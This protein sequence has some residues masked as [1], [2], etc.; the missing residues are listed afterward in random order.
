MTSLQTTGQLLLDDAPLTCSGC[1][2]GG[3][4]DLEERGPRE[5]WPAWIS[6]RQ[7]GHGED[8]QV[9]TN[10][11][12]AAAAAA[13]TGR[14]RAEDADTFTAEWRHLTLAGECVPEFVLDDAV[15]LGQEL[16]KIG[17][18]EIKARKRKARRWF[19]HSTTNTRQR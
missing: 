8:H 6:C 15:T 5:T 16:A 17:R 3:A 11:L 18:R 7:C 12:V 2:V 9:I 13:R 19:G 4:L 14:Q 10:G 1:G